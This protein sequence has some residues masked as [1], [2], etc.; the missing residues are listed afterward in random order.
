MIWN[1][2]NVGLGMEFLGLLETQVPSLGSFLAWFL[3]SRFGE[4]VKE[5]EEE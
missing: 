4:V 1:V 3:S 5:V 2:K